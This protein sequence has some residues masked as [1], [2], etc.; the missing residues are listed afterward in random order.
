MAYG[1]KVKNSNSSVLTLH[2]GMYSNRQK[3]FIHQEVSQLFIVRKQIIHNLLI[4]TYIY[5]IIK[6]TLFLA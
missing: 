3:K 1:Q 4:R 6:K 2:H 5:L